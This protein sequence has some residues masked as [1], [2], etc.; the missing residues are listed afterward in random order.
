MFPH[1]ALL[2]DKVPDSGIAYV[3]LRVVNLVPN[4]PQAD[5]KPNSKVKKHWTRFGIRLRRIRDK[6][7]YAATSLT[8]GVSGA[9]R[10]RLGL[11]ET[12]G[13]RFQC[14]GD[15]T[16]DKVRDKVRDKVFMR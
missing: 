1:S 9:P 7:S 12:R 16:Q 6:V 8:L 14:S 15:K 4:P 13:F 3:R 2:S 5:H 10:R 11:C